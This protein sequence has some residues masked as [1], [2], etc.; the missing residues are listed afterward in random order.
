MTIAISLKINDGIIFATDSAATFFKKNENGTGVEISNVYNNANKIFNLKKGLPIGAITWGAGS[1][2]SSSTST[3]VKDFRELITNDDAWKI[4]EENYT[5]EEIVIKFNK[6]I[7][8]NNYKPVY[9]S[10]VEKPYLGFIL[11]GYSSGKSESEVWSIEYPGIQNNDYNIQKLDSSLSWRGQ[12][13][14]ITRLVLGI[15]QNLIDILNKSEYVKEGNAQQLFN[16]IREKSE[17]QFIQPA[18]PIQDGIDLLEF[19]VLTAKDY[20]KYVPGSQTVGGPTEIA[21]ITKHEG[22]KWIKRKHFY[23]KEYN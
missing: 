2:N 4:N 19:L 9:N 11:A 14:P 23:S 10:V 5:I 21:T 3:L 6:F 20:Y 17:V 22:F 15:S 12:P 1:I 13:E 18:M 16:Q 8:D 7:Y